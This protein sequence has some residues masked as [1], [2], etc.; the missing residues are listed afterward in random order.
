[1]L[2]SEEIEYSLGEVYRNNQPVSFRRE[3]PGLGRVTVDFEE[4]TG[5]TLHHAT[6]L[7]E[8]RPLLIPVHR[9]EPT[10]SMF[11]QLEGGCSF[12]FKQ[13]VTVPENHHALCYLPFLQTNYYIGPN[14]SRKDL[15]IWFNP[16][17]VAAQMLEEEI[18]DDHWQRLM[19]APEQ[20]FSTVRQS[21][22]MSRK[23]TDTLVQVRSCPFSGKLGR[24]YK[25]S[26]IRLLFIDQLLV[27]RQNQLRSG[28]PA[29]R[30]TRQ[31]IEKLHELKYFLDRNFLDDLS[32][33]ALTREFGLNSFK[34]KHGFRQLFDTSVMR[35]IDDLK[36]GYARR[37]LLDADQDVLEI[38][39]Q[40]GYNHYSNF[41]AAF[42]RRFGIPPTAVARPRPV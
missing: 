36:M 26:L 38:A 34:L 13:E 11:F 23:M 8:N 42:K 14:T 3:Q 22:P 25:D 20:I 17:V 18:E 19:E 24:T 6:F 39:D 28:E 31:D 1:M 16:Q 9:P 15:T 2:T 10:V 33:T 41:S 32:L 37:L 4:L 27:Y 7:T 12:Q 5:A 35:Y 40:L 30:L 21:R 29:T